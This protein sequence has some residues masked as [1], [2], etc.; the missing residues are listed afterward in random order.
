[1]R[2]ST[3]LGDIKESKQDYKTAKEYFRKSLAISET[4]NHNLTIGAKNTHLARI[5]SFEGHNRSARQHLRDGLQALW[6][7]GYLWACPFPLVCMAEM[8]VESNDLVQAVE[9]LGTN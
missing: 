8:L 5:A 1:M 6:D 4:F 9:I 7:A 2:A 3:V